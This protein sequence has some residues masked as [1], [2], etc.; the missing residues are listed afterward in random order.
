MNRVD[1]KP[2]LLRWARDRAKLSDEV[3]ERRFPKF[4]AW[5]SRELRPTLKQLEAFARA[6]YT[7]IGFLFLS[8]P[9]VEELPIPD[10]R[11]HRNV[12]PNSLSPDLLDTIYL[13][14]QRQDWYRDFAQSVGQEP[15]DFV[16]SATVETDIVATAENIRKRL[17]LDHEERRRIPTW[18]EALRLLVGQADAMGVLVMVSGVVGSNNRRKLDPSEFRGFSLSDSLSPLVFVN[19][20]DT[21]AGQMFTLAHEIAHI[22]L[23]ESGVSDSHPRD[24]PLEGVELWCNSVAAE[25]LMPLESLLEV[26]NPRNDLQQ[27]MNRL[28]RTFKVSTLVVL[29]RIHDAGGLGRQEFWEAYEEEL[30]RVLS[31]PRGSGG[32]FYLTLG[33]RASKRF[34]RALVVSTLEG[35][36]PYT[37]AFRLLGFKKMSTF[38]QVGESLGVMG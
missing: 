26:Y 3:L 30:L 29:R 28:A 5:E 14:Q 12:R 36:T 21:R 7:P 35:R 23:G 16:S 31:L 17:G 15:L 20:A 18:T 13:C 19:G 25:L 37:Q 9:P 32:N 27:E 34:A 38:H 10:F 2:E 24:F 22:W 4:P 8:A 1:V 6:T 11:T 33:A